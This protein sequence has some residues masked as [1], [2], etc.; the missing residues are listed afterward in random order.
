[1]GDRGGR[2]AQRL[3]FR[4]GGYDRRGGDHRRHVLLRPI[5]QRINRQP[6]DQSELSLPYDISVTS[7]ERDEETCRANV[8]AQIRATMLLLRSLESHS[9]GHE[10][11]QVKEAGEAETEE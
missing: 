10:R 11:V 8:L 4:Y 5:V 2:H 6:L 3:R 7:H 9:V 1:L